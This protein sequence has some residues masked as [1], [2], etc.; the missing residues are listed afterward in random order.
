M[1]FSD[2]RENRTSNTYL[3]GF[4]YYL[5]VSNRNNFTFYYVFQRD[6]STNSVMSIET[7]WD[8]FTPGI[9]GVSSNFNLYIHVS[10]SQIKISINPLFNLSHKVN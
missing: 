7:Y 6:A 8:K 2:S 1:Y 4:T 5:E 9:D 3:F 10:K